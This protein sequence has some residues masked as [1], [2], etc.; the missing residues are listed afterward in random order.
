MINLC[1]V[2]NLR[3]LTLAVTKICRPTAMQ[4]EENGV[5]VGRSSDNVIDN[6]TFRTLSRIELPIQL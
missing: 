6:A 4:N 1:Y 3:F 5:V 2:P